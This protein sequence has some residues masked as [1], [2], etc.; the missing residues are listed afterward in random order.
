MT[1]LSRTA[2]ACSMLASDGEIIREP[3]TD[4]AHGFPDGLACAAL[5]VAQQFELT[6]ERKR[7]NSSRAPEADKFRTRQGACLHRPADPWH[8]VA[9]PL[10]A[11]VK[12]LMNVSRDDGCEQIT[13]FA[14]MRV[15]RSQWASPRGPGRETKSESAFR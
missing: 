7:V 1:R 9:V 14:G 5:A 15:E 10:F 11:K 4:I 12:G 3:Y 13:V 6:W 8:D 2:G